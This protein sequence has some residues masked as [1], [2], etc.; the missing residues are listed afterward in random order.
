[1]GH[2]TFIFKKVRDEFYY[3]GLTHSEMTKGIKNIKLEV[4]PNPKDERASYIRNY[5]T[6]EKVKKIRE[7]DKKI[8]YQKK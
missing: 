3:V 6:H 4:N 7:K 1:M 5:S 2:P 8:I